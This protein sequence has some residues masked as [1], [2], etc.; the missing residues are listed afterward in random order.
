MSRPATTH[1]L[2]AVDLSDTAPT[3]IAYA[4]DLAQLHN[5]RFTVLHVV[6]DLSYYSGVFI[7]GKPLA[8]LQHDLEVEARE[9]LDALCQEAC[10]DA[11]S[12]A[13]FTADI[14]TGRP[15]AEVHH[16]IVE[17][18]VD[19]LVIGAHSIDKPEHQLFGSTAE[20]LLHQIRCP[21]IVVPPDR[22]VDYVSH[23]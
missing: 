13:A 2:A 21:T 6:H 12:D 8:T 19:C 14:V 18:G 23:G 1:I 9:R 17:R 22:I 5:A 11:S 20:R 7:T 10:K 4:F 15:V 16:A 3:V